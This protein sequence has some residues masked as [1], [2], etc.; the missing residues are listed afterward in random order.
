MQYRILVFQQLEEIII[1]IFEEIFAQQRFV[2]RFQHLVK[3]HP[4]CIHGE[5]QLHAVE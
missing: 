5:G 3:H 2:A 1:V 4:E